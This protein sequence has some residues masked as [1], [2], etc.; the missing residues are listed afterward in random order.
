M[1]KNRYILSFPLWEAGGKDIVTMYKF[2]IKVDNMGIR[3]PSFTVYGIIS[4]LV[5]S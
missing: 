3:F 1:R 4:L 5:L 2:S